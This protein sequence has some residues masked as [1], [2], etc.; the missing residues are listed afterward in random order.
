MSQAVLYHSSQCFD[1]LLEFQKENNF[2]INTAQIILH[3]LM[4]FNAQ[5]HRILIRDNTILQRLI[6]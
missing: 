1:L 2:K 5:Y 3:T 6:D 4:S